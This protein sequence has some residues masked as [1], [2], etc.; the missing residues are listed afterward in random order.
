MKRAKKLIWLLMTAAVFAAAPLTAMAL[1]AGGYV[2]TSGTYYYKD[3]TTNNK[4][5]KNNSVAYTYKDDGRI[6]KRTVTYKGIGSVTY[7]YTWKGNYITKYPNSYSDVTTF[8]YSKKKLVSYRGSYASKAQKITWKGNTGT[9]TQYDPTTEYTINN[10]GQLIKKVI[11][12]DGEFTDIST[13]QYYGNGNLKSMSMTS[14]SD[15]D[16]MTGTTTVTYNKKGYETSY[17]NKYGSYWAKTTYKYTTKKGKI[18]Q[19][20]SNYSNSN[21]SKNSSKVVYK[22]WQYVSHVR[23]CDAWGRGAVLAFNDYF[24]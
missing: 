2:P 20:V 24:D 18:T 8:K 6:T 12:Y 1:P 13:Y 22:K 23:N 17:T 11:K 10:K 7:K 15:Y 5:K 19:V 21:G 3:S 16:T 9:V 4:W 14:K